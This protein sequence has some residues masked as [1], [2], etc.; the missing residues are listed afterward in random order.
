MP[1]Q[2]QVEEMDVKLP[3]GETVTVRAPGGLS[4]D[5]IKAMLMKKMPE[6][7]RPAAPGPPAVNMSQVDLATG[8]PNDNDPASK[9]GA[10][11]LKSA[12]GMATGAEKLLGKINPTP[13]PSEEMRRMEE[14]NKPSSGYE[15]AGKTTADV[16]SMLAPGSAI[17]GAGIVPALGRALSTGAVS[18]AQGGTWTAAGAGAGAS[19]AGDAIQ[20][21]VKALQ[22]SVR[23]IKDPAL[24]NLTT[25][26]RDALSDSGSDIDQAV[27]NVE[28]VWQSAPKE[29]RGKPGAQKIYQQVMDQV[30]GGKQVMP[31]GLQSKYEAIRDSMDRYGMHKAAFGGIAG[32]LYGM[33]EGHPVEGALGGMALGASPSLAVRALPAAGRAAPS[34]M[35]PLP[36]LVRNLYQNQQ[37]P[38]SFGGR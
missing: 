19:L 29:I 38:Q 28:E 11:V 12:T 36:A 10:G 6:A 18:G 35:T 30:Q 21:G 16:L 31:S 9:L 15:Q 2:P 24:R 37:P 33:H 13:V 27:A 8:R 5:A 22:T 25:A 4:D 32:G 20:A 26:F 23:G 3:T 17:K 14:F 1:Q 7:F 34:L